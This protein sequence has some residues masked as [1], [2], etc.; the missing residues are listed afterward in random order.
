MVAYYCFLNLFCAAHL[1]SNMFN[2]QSEQLF[3][4]ESVE[5]IIG[6]SSEGPTSLPGEF[7]EKLENSSTINIQKNI[8]GFI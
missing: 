4:R 3:T 6:R 1:A 5:H 7:L 2:D 8:K